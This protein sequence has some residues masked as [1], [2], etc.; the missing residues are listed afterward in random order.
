[1]LWVTATMSSAAAPDLGNGDPLDNAI[2]AAIARAL[3]WIE[4]NRATPEEGGLTDMIDEG[5]AF[6]FFRDHAHSSSQRDRF[7]H[8]LRNQMASLYALAEFQDWVGRPDKS[9]IEHY[10]LVLAAHLAAVSGLKHPLSDTIRTQ[11]QSALAAP[12]LGEPTVRLTTALFLMRLAGGA[13]LDTESLLAASMIERLSR[14]HRHIALP[15]PGAPP[16]LQHRAIWSLYALVHELVALTD[17]GQRPVSPWL[18][19]RRS[20]VVEV[21][22]EAVTWASTQNNQ[23]LT[24]ELIVTLYFLGES[25]HPSLQAAL[26][27]LLADQEQDGSWGASTTTTRLNRVRHSV[28]TCSAALAAYLDWRQQ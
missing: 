26:D 7:A 25:L 19:S 18:A 5:V 22:L 16:Y 28:L 2:R 8:L 15:G 11:A 12:G 21:L 10:H 14:D 9:L 13:N 3:A 20:A 1:M 4:N 6:R 27:K 23:D 24:A 17:F